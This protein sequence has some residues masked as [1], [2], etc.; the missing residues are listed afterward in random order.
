MLQNQGIML[1]FDANI[2]S[3]LCFT[4]DHYAPQVAHYAHTIL[5][6]ETCNSDT[7][8]RKNTNTRTEDKSSLP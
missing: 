8:S 3:L 4:K 2:V 6:K 1:C 7:I 5:L